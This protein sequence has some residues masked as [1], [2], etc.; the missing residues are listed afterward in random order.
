MLLMNRS[1]GVKALWPYWVLGIVMWGFMLISGVHATIAGVLTAMTVPMRSPGGHSP[2]I[3][4]EHAL[5]PWV[6]F[7]IMPI[8]AL[9]NAGV[10]LH[11]AGIES[12]LHPIALGVAAGLVFGKPIGITLTTLIASKILRQQMPARLPRMIGISILAGI[13]FTMSLFIGTLAFG[14]GDLATPVRFGVL[15]GSFVSAIVG[16]AVLWWCC[17][18]P[19]SR[20]HRTLGPEEDIA[21]DRGVLEDIDPPPHEPTPKAP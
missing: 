12:V 20:D 11:G 18:A 16:L 14:G 19:P 5:K 7:A 21:E 3:T 17:R 9:A 15:G 8:F 6:M 13:G 2:L 10:V 4:A 1:G